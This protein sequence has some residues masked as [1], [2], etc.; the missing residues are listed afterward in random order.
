MSAVIEHFC[1]PGIHSGARME[2]DQE[3]PSVVE[4]GGLPEPVPSV[5]TSYADATSE[6]EHPCVD[7]RLDLG[8]CSESS[9]IVFLRLNINCKDEQATGGTL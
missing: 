8:V 9:S 7:Q 5:H 4:Q 2:G 1:E 6:V 3:V